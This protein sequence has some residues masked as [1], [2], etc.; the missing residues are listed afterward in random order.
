[1]NRHQRHAETFRQL[2][3]P[4][5]PL[6][7]VNIWDA[8]SARIVSENGAPAIAT[9]S[10]SVAAAKGEQDG[11]RLQLQSLLETVISISRTVDLPLT[12]D[13]EAGYADDADA[14]GANIARLIEAGAIGC[15]LEDGIAGSDRMRTID[16]QRTRLG[17]ARSAANGNGIPLFINART[18]IFL[19]MPVE[20]HARHIGDAIARAHAYAEAGAD[21]FFV[22]G[23]TDFKLMEQIAKASPLPVNVMI[24]DMKA[25]LRPY[26]A[27]G[28]A[29]ASY[30]PYPW[31]LA[32]GVLR[33]AVR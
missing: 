29:R 32:M 14:V 6:V 9:S 17:S 15:N 8:G 2:H 31:L 16:E 27:A 12:V 3:I 21:G 10:W 24:S 7:L 22:P 20:Q 33:D 18:D 5:R 30:G 26:A 25:D 28:V 1:M 11:E 23:L 4:G 19:L 13:F